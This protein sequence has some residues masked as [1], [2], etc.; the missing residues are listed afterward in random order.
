[1]CDYYEEIKD[2]EE[3]IKEKEKEIKELYEFKERLEI[4][5][6]NY[7]VKLDDLIHSRDSIGYKLHN[8]QFRIDNYEPDE[9]E[10]SIE[11][12]KKERDLYQA[13][14]NLANKEL[15]DFKEEYK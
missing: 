10:V 5:E 14:W 8:I 15:D 2:I 4:M 11:E 9:D 13:K 3:Q 7:N 6:H 1:M 12:L